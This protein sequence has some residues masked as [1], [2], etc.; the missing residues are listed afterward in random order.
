MTPHT[1]PVC[2]GKGLLPCGFYNTQSIGSPSNT[3]DEQCRACG[4]QGIIW[5]SNQEIT[6]G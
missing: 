3:A 6:L 2:N 4:G 1:C 5:E